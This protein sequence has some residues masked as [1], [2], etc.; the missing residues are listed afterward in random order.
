[1]SI[2]K[3]NGDLPAPNVTKIVNQLK[4]YAKWLGR[5]G[6]VASVSEI[7][8]DVA[9]AYQKGENVGIQILASTSNTA[10]EAASTWAVFELG[11]AGGSLV[12]TPL[13]GL[14]TGTVTAGFASFRYN[15]D[16]SGSS[17]GGSSLSSQ[18]K[19]GFKEIYTGI[20]NVHNNYENY[21]K[22]NP[23]VWNHIVR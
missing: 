5:R 2:Y 3:L 6:A 1:M 13:F 17:S 18:F 10:V 4:P 19:T 8:F 20:N 14:V 9:G 16:F 7:G 15:Y 11:F 23:S 12:G 22:D 21:K